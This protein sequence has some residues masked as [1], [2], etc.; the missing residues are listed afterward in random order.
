[1][2]VSGVEGAL[3]D[4]VR[5]ALL[6]RPN[7]A[8]TVKEVQED[9]QRV[10]DTGYFAACRPLAEDT[11]DG[12]RLTVEVSPNPELRGVVARGGGALPASEVQAAFAGLRGRT[13]NFNAFAAAVA[14]LNGWYE[15]Q[16]VL[17]QVVDVELGAGDVMQV[18]LAEA[19]V[20]SIALRYVD[21][22]T[23]EARQEGRTRPEVVLRQLATRPGQVY[24]LRRAKADIEAVYAMGLFEDVGIRPQP[25]EGSTLEAP[26]VDLTLEL[27]ERRKTG[28]LSAGGGISAAGATEGAMPGFVGTASYSQRNLFGLGQRL[29][30][31]AEVGQLDSTFRVAHTDPWVR[32]DAW[33]TSRTVSAQ[34]TKTSAAPIHGRAADEAGE[35]GAA[36]AQRCAGCG[37]RRRGGRPGGGACARPPAG[38][39]GR[40]ACYA[41][42]AAR[43]EACLCAVLARAC[44]PSR[45]CTAPPPS[46]L[47]PPSAPLCLCLPAAMRCTCLGWSAPWSTRAP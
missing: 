10:F 46:P 27:K 31:S 1:V 44:D 20:S 19:T 41:G 30:A 39:R 43:R 8:Y 4:V 45:P 2:E 3:R 5:S 13:L 33:R 42:G 12:V 6:T 38:A 9:V 11:R 18:R 7:F 35:P 21:P 36:G 32:G 17:G 16:G 34:S 24:S 29:T 23:G 47:T 25:A 14:R 15:A 22:K 40:R 28:G 37:R 26:R